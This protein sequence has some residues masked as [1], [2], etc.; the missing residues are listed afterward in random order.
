[1][2]D[3]RLRR[4]LLP[5]VRPSPVEKLGDL[6]GA[7]VGDFVLREVGDGVGLQEGDDGEVPIRRLALGPRMGLELL[8]HL[9]EVRSRY[10]LTEFRLDSDLVEEVVGELP[11]LVEVGSSGPP[12]DGAVSVGP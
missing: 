4:R 6:L 8:G 1:M 11:R 12:V 10:G 2:E 9:G 7:D 5:R 3:R